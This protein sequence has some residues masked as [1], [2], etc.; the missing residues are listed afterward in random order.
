MKKFKGTRYEYQAL[1][2]WVAKQLGRPSVCENC[3]TLEA[4]RYEWA[5]ISDSYLKD[6]SDWARLCPMCH[7]LIDDRKGELSKPTCGKGHDMS[8]YNEAYKTLKRD[9]K[10][11]RYCRKCQVQYLRDFR[12]KQK[13]LAT[14]PIKGKDRL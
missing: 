5:N 1:H 6:I 3:G 9:G 7:C 13:R 14:P 2:A 4:P 12:A 8:G 10:K 11:F